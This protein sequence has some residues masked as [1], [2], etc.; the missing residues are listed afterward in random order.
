MNRK[1]F[2]KH[3]MDITLLRKLSRKSTLKFGQYYDNTV[4]DCLTFHKYN[5]LRWVYYNCSMVTFMDDI[6]EEIGITQEYRINKP[7]TDETKHQLLCNDLENKMSGLL[8]H[9]IKT[10]NRKQQRIKSAII[11]RNGSHHF[12]KDALRRKNQ[13]V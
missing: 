7:G 13:G 8:K 3:N 6:L 12:T 5:Y 2:K 9:I 1:R 4:Q 10:K 11:E